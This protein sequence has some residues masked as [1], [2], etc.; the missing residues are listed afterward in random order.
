MTTSVVP[1]GVFVT[2]TLAATI[3][4]GTSTHRLADG[5]AWCASWPRHT[6]MKNSGMMKPPFQPDASVSADAAS[7]PTRRQH[8]R[9]DGQVG[10]PSVQL[11]DLV[12]RRR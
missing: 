12:P 5:T 9:A 3:R 6:P 11:A 10:L 1:I 2:P 7:L 8:Q 4:H